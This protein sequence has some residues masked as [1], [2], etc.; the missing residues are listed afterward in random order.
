MAVFGN[1]DSNYQPY[2]E[3]QQE[4]ALKTMK[5]SNVCQKHYIAICQGIQNVHEKTTKAMKEILF[6]SKRFD[7]GEWVYGNLIGNDAIVGEIVL[8]E[9][10]FLVPNF[11][12]KSILKQLECS[13]GWKTIFVADV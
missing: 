7:N 4:K 10:E 8:F 2:S 5:D 13:Q 3:S 11:G 12:I 6:G 1:W 9:D